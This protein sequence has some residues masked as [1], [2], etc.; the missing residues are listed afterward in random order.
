M[1]ILAISDFHGAVDLLGDIEKACEHLS[2]DL[3][4][5]TGDVV[6]GH[7]RGDEWLS[8]L[9]EKRKPRRDKPEILHEEEEDLRFY[10][11]FYKTLLKLNL[12]VML[13]PGNMDAPEDRFLKRLKEK[14]KE[15]PHLKLVHKE[16]IK[17]G[18]YIFCGFGGE[19]TKKTKEGYLVLVYP[20]EEVKEYL[21]SLIGLG[22][23]VVFLSHTPPLGKLDLEGRSH[24]GSKIVNEIIE[25]ISPK[26]LFCGHAHK[27]KGKEIIGKTLVV[28][29]GALKAGNLALVD[30]QTLEVKFHHLKEL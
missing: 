30:T 28:N 8:S 2:P 6:K 27:A 19:V 25:M 4:T 3:I 13:I 21:S 5:F 12:P 18:G 16:R 1:R 14:L 24:K 20:R 26:V 10:D 11:E 9:A 29:P 7:A 22:K 15:S 17:E 23:E